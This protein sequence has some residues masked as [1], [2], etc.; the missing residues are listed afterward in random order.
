M[1]L[2]VLGPNRVFGWRRLVGPLEK[3]DELEL[4]IEFSGVAAWVQEITEQPRAP[5]VAAA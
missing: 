5:S 1:E 4:E 3:E 2:H